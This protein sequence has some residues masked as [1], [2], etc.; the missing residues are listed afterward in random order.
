MLSRPPRPPARFDPTAQMTMSP[1]EAAGPRV[2][3]VVEEVASALSAD[4][5]SE[6][7]T[8]SDF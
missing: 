8:L 7:G 2:E 6:N 5:S 3:E 1:R 4:W